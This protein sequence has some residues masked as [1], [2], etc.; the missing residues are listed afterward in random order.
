MHIGK[1]PSGDDEGDSERTDRPPWW[2]WGI[3]VAAVVVGLIVGVLSS[4]A[5][6]D[7]ADLAASESEVDLIV[8]EPIVI[9]TPEATRDTPFQVPLYNAG[10]LDIELLWIRPQGWE[11][12]ETAVRGP[13]T[14]PPDVWVPVRVRAVPNCD[15]VATADVLEMRV[16]TRARESTVSLPLP[17]AGI[18]QEA[19]TV[20]CRP[21][22]PVGAYIEEVRVVPSSRP[23]TLTMRLQLRAYDPNLRFTLT[24]VSATAPGFRL[25]DATVPVQFERGARSI[26]LVTTWEVIGCEATL[27]L[28]EVNLGLG[29]R[30]DAGGRQRDGAELPGRGLA[31]LARFGVE[32]CAA[33]SN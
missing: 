9:D 31:E 27:T 22:S 29:F 30:D 4:N 5:R 3:V 26:P 32:Q 10:P 20:L 28:N 7:A 19:Q 13:T 24:D 1:Q 6:Q 17:R 14:L 8:G 12:A 11:V 23:D 2:Q 25:I 16:R 18:M 15:E 21:F 33:T